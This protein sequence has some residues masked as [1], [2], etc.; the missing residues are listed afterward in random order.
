MV[1][2]LYLSLIFLSVLLL[3]LLAVDP[4]VSNLSLFELDRLVKSGNKKAKRDLRRRKLQGD[5]L[6]L[7]LVM[8]FGLIIIWSIIATANFGWL[9]GF[10][11]TLVGVGLPIVGSHLGVIKRLAGVIYQPFELRISNLVEN[12]P[13]IARLVRLN[14][15]E[16]VDTVI[17]SREELVNVI[18]RLKSILPSE[19]KSLIALALSMNDSKVVDIMIPR[20]KISCISQKELLGPLVLNDL[21]KTG[22]QLFMAI[23]KDIDHIVGA[24]D[25]SSQLVI[26]GQS[27]TKSVAEV[28]DRSVIVGSSQLTIKEAITSLVDS[29]AKAMVIAH[30]TKTYGVVYLVDVINLFLGRK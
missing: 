27:E 2:A 8:I 21:H 17:N 29:N 5:L 16:Q 4:Q 1:I 20:E 23:D 15:P 13:F 6:S 22:D 10:L 30:D 7:R 14:M 25:I 3:L 24:L 28:M 26:D 9:M 11:A 19:E 12:K 18:S